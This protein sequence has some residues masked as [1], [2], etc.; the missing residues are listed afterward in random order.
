MSAALEDR[1]PEEPRFDE[2]RFAALLRAEGLVDP[3]G[4]DRARLV[5]AETG[6]RLDR[7][8]THLGLVAE[9]PVASVLAACH[10]LD[11]A[12]RAD[13]PDALPP[14]AP[15]LRFLRHAGV[16]P[17][18]IGANPVRLA[19]ADPFDGFARRAVEMALGCPVVPC[20]AVPADI[21]A[22]FER[23]SRGAETETGA[24]APASAPASAEDSDVDRLRDRAS[25]APIIRLVN[26]MIARAIDQ[27]ASDIHVEPFETRLRV[28]Y[29]IDGVLREQDNHPRAMAAAIVSRI[30]LMA[31]LDIAD[32][33][34]PQD[35][36]M[37]LAVRGR[38]IDFRIATAPTLHGESVVL[39][40]LDM[41]LVDLDFPSLGLEEPGCSLLLRELARPNGILLV[42]GPT[43]SGKTTTLYTG[44]TI[45][46]RPERKILTVEDPIEYQLPG[47]NQIQ[48]RPDIGLTFAQVLRSALRH[49]PDVLMVG[50]IR[51]L[52]TAEIAVQA[53]LTG[54]LVLSTLHTNGAAAS[55]TR[56]LEIGV[57]DYLVVSTVTSVVAQ[58]LVRR[59]C[60]ACRRPH[61]ALP[62]MAEELGLDR[63][64]GA[65]RPTL[66]RPGGCPACDGTG[67]R[68]RLGLY[69]ILVLD[70][71]LRRAVL[72]RSDARTLHGM[73]VERGMRTL[74]DDGLLK[75]LSGA[76]ALDEVLRVTRAEI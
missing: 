58:R 61:P 29:R 39:R 53:A 16:L 8:L 47:I 60:P 9:A 27:R 66:Y 45:L 51:D 31:G 35:G 7:V 3:A 42:T 1:G 37:K 59:L 21:E 34:L 75:A 5:A 73:A 62:E 74:F 72:A 24:A 68:G 20:L 69:E 13:Y 19:M 46:N 40:I 54:H 43:G 48:V 23:L 28:R 56:L 11:L 52:E 26:Q 44:L 65:A 76:T 22:A 50:E 10:G 18:D 12:G 6:D 4:L 49:D 63:L 57:P 17:L 64:A 25:E 70:E 36:R 55:I 2:T 15:G 71:S 38:D 41:R 14:G 33:R 30:K 67:Y 32:R